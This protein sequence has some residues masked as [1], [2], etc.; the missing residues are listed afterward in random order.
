M[1]GI[2]RFIY[3][4]KEW[5]SKEGID[6][7]DIDKF[8]SQIFAYTESFKFN[9]VVSSFMILLNENKTKSLTFECKNQLTELLK[10]YIPGFKLNTI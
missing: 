1:I 2:R 7:I 10:I 9:K 8:K 6:H 4:M 5:L 3:R